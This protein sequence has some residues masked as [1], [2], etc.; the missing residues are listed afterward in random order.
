[1]TFL[2]I[3]ETARRELGDSEEDI[4]WVTQAIIHSDPA[5]HLLLMSHAPSGAERMLIETA[6]DPS[7]FDDWDA[8]LRGLMQKQI[9][10]N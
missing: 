6:K 5:R 8:V 1:M 7:R 4:R 10:N 9:Q 2:E 3:L